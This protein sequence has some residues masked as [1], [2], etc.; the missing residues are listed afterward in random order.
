V[1]C[2]FVISLPASP[3]HPAQSIASD[4]LAKIGDEALTVTTTS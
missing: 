4:L 2:I 3:P 1:N